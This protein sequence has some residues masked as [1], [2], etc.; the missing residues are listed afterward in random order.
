MKWSFSQLCTADRTT[1]KL[2][3]GQYEYLG[4]NVP[5]MGLRNE[6]RLPTYHHDISAT[7]TPRKNKDRNWK[8]EWVL[9]FIIYI[10]GK[11]SFH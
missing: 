5:I 4:I 11:C 6:N 3:N 10:T 7:L 2:S 9:V 1:Y 8:G